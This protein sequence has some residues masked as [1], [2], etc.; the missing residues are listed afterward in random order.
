MKSATINVN[1]NILVWARKERGF[2]YDDIAN[3]LGKDVSIIKEWENT[4]ENLTFSELKKIAKTYK[5]Q[6]SVFFLKEV[7]QATKIP[8]DRRNLRVDERGLDPETLLAVRRTNRYLRIA[9]DL[10]D[11]DD[12][13][14]QYKWLAELIKHGSLTDAA[15]KLRDLLQV[16]VD[17]QKKCSGSESAL[18]MWRQRIETKLG[19]YTFQ[20]LMPEN[21]I[22]GFSYVEEGAPYAVT[23][24][25]R[26]AKNRQIFTL[27]HE[28]GHILEGSSGICL[29]TSSVNANNAERRCDAFSADFLLPASTVKVPSNYEELKALALEMCVSAEAYARRAYGLKMISKPA[30]YIFLEQIASAPKNKKSNDEMRISPLVLSKS[31]RGEKFFNLI[32]DAYD[33]G[34]VSGS[35][36][37]DI[38]KIRPTRIDRK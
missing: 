24:N 14:S 2:E 15:D 35:V 38:L 26:N 30:L 11:D 37:A 7:P 23:L 8:K 5:R 33:S 22:D 34:R 9:R 3:K 19:I 1:P 13:K 17:D 20:F 31:R 32:L 12:I 21:E 18:R 10:S 28:I 29:T 16:S 25:S 36:V 6:V 4:G 27:F